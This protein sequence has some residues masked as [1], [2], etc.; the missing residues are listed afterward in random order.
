MRTVLFSVFLFLN[1]TLFAQQ[2]NL[3]GQVLSV[4]DHPIA[5]AVVKL[6]SLKSIVETD[7]KG[8]FM[9][10]NIDAYNTV[11]EVSHVGYKTYKATIL[12]PADS[13]IKIVLTDSINDLQ[14]VQVS[15][16]YQSLPREQLT[17]AF[18]L[19]DNKLLN[20][21]ISTDIIS[22]LDGLVP[23]VLFDKRDGGTQN[24][25]VRGRSTLADRVSLSSPLIVVDN[26]PYQGDINSINPNDIENITFLKD[27]AAASIW[28]AKAGNGVLV[29]TTKKGKY[30][31][32]N[33]IALTANATWVTAPDLYYQ[34]RMSTSEFIDTEIFLYENGAYNAYLN[35]TTTRPPITP[36]VEL[37]DSMSRGLLSE[38][39]GYEQ[40]NHFRTRD[41]RKDYE[42]YFYRNG[43]NQQYALNFNGG[44]ERGHYMVAAGFDRNLEQLKENAL[45]RISVRTNYTL[46]LTKQ[47]TFDVGFAYISRR[48]VLNNTGEPGLSPSVTKLYPYATLADEA[49][50]PLPIEQRYRYNYITQAGEGRLLDWTYRPL[51]EIYL[52]DHVMKNQNLT[53]NARLHYA[54]GKDFSAEFRY[55]YER[56]DEGEHNFRSNEL[57]Y[58]RDLINRY[59]QL[60][61]SNVVRPIPMGGILDYGSSDMETHNGRVQLNYKKDWIDHRI[62]AMLGGEIRQQAF[63]YLRNRAYGYDDDLKT[64]SP[65]D[66][67]TRFP[68]FDGLG[69]STSIPNEQAFGTSLSRF[70][71][72]FGNTSYTYKNRYILTASIRRDASN[73]FG[74]ATNNK[75][76]PLWSTGLKWLI[77]EES[78]YHSSWLPLLS[79]KASY[80]KSGNVNNS[81]AAL[82][83]IRY[84][85]SPSLLARLPYA[86]VQNPPNPDLKWENVSQW[87]LG[88]N[89]STKGNRL[90]GSLEYYAKR[91]TDL[92]ALVNADITTGF[93]VLN[94]NSGV[95]SNKGL[96]FSLTS[97]NLM[98]KFNWTSNFFLSANKN[99][100]VKLDYDQ[101]VSA[102]SLLLPPAKGY[103]LNSLFSYRFGGLDHETGDPVGFD[104]EGNR[105]VDYISLLYP[106][107]ANELVYNGSLLPQVFGGL[108][109]DFTYKRFTLSVNITYRMNYVYRRNTIWYSML[110]SPNTVVGHADYA[111]R[112]QQSGD[113]LKTTVPALMYPANSMRDQFY[114]ESEAT[115]EKGDH[116]RLQ[117]INLRYTVNGGPRSPFNNFT[118]TFYANN[119][120]ILW[121]ASKND[122]DP[123]YT[124][125][126]PL[127]TYALG[128]NLN[129]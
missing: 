42:N 121:K 44:T 90:N 129:F 83:T 54:F 51:E 126:P 17:G 89:F 127:R 56:Q 115:V 61:G 52:A 27:A 6:N 113:E 4:Q 108:R 128:I 109:N 93:A 49:G 9:I 94:R 26:F 23:G 107:S 24:F 19:V 112:W 71:S 58:T 20:R 96:D 123:D 122:I 97:E 60:D 63:S 64:S 31:Q 30:G 110:L 104:S 105:S 22:R 39:R 5:G 33:R 43:F 14:E 28:G 65:V 38:Q 98:G 69:S 16:G 59:T 48:Q 21:Q 78:F 55:Q 41:V 116:L 47:M 124:L 68:M 37:L 3:R 70:I 10:G 45:N 82:T 111:L 79:L 103:P 75:W 7:A 12:L 80:G 101:F 72:L 106:Q 81:V 15:T 2:H 117:D 125:N 13:I 35:N 95:V 118:F 46:R 67:V 36:V 86:T 100:L 18:E 32:S 91:S 88:L 8:F 53:A 57:F 85:S 34:P 87:N 76:K 99:K 119:L 40:I 74:T 50:N 29:I 11:L 1:Q 66:L 114:A 120:G 77:N 102:S 73:L 25:L 62:T 92:L 84:N